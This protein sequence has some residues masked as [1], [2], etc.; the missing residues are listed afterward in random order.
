MLLLFSGVSTE[1]LQSSWKKV[2]HFN[3]MFYFCKNIKEVEYE[4]R[5]INYVQ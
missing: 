5:K 4:N 3:F 1:D 2:S